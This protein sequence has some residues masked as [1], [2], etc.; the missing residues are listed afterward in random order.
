M[1]SAMEVPRHHN[2]HVDIIIAL[3][4]VDEL[5]FHIE[6]TTISQRSIITTTATVTPTDRDQNIEGLLQ[7]QHQEIKIY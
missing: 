4:F 2:R 7:L 3:V 6:R 1:S 5:A